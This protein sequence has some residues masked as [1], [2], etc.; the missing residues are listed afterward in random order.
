MNYDL[1]MEKQISNIKEGTKL[2]LHACCA[3]CSS[4]VLERIGN[5]FEIT[6][7]YYNPNITDK[8]E[9][10]KRVEELKKFI[11]KIKTKYKISLIE[12]IYE[13]NDF[14]KIA[15]GLENEP[16]KGARCYKCYELR[17]EETANIAEK[18]NFQFFCTTLT[19]SPHKNAN[20][21]NEIGSILDKKYN[22]NYLY[23]DFK[24]KNGYKRSIELSKEYNLYRQDY[25][26]CIYSYKN[27]KYE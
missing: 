22:T 3:P 16:E 6:I 9:Y 26:G 4:A 12:G 2:L 18:L 7:F 5:Y 23:S 15:K 10:Q 8:K 24:K 17:L 20:W 19:L 27:K 11:S 21:I 13:P 14:F 1:E 25:C